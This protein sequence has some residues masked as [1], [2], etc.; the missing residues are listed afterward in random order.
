M[1]LFECTGEYVEQVQR[2]I[3]AENAQEAEATFRDM[4]PNILNVRVKEFETNRPLSSNLL[5]KALRLYPYKKQK[6]VV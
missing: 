3:K 5:R 2:L 1:T 4:Q 6:G